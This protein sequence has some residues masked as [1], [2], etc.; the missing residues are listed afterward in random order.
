MASVNISLKHEAYQRLLALKRPDE[1][2]S[3]EVLRLIDK[4][5]QKEIMGSFGIWKDLSKED[6]R[7]MEEGIKTS[8][9]KTL[10][11]L[12]KWEK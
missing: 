6:I 10:K 8:R 5:P 7:Q 9:M 12:E 11:I 4:R 1:S 3:D 2:F